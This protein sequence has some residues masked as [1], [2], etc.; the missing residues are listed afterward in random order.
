[1]F[2]LFSQVSLPAILAV[3]L[4]AMSYHPP[5]SA[6][7]PLVPP[8][9]SASFGEEVLELESV[10]IVADEELEPRERA[11]A[12]DVLTRA[13]IPEAADGVPL[14]L[15]IA[16]VPIREGTYPYFEDIRRQ[17]YRLTAGPDGI[18]IEGNSP[19]AVFHG[20]QTLDQLLKEQAIRH[21]EVHDWPDLAV[22]MIMVDP[23]RQNEN[24]DYYRRVIDFASR[25]KINA[26]LCHLTDDQTS[27]LHHED[28]PE[29]LHHEAWTPEQVE[30]LVAYAADRHIELIPEIESLGHSRMFER[31]PDFE[32]YLHQ[33]EDD[34]PDESWYGTD[35]PGYT[36]VLC[37]AS[38]KAVRYLDEMYGLAAETFGHDW[39]HVGFDEVDLTN[40]ARCREVFG[41]QTHDEWMIAALEQ[42]DRLVRQNAGR[43]GLWGDM[44]LAHPG[45]ADEFAGSDMLIFDWYY[46]AD[47][48]DESVRFFLDRDYEIIASPALACAPHMVIPD[49]NN[50]QN[51]ARFTAIA[52]E[53]SLLGVN[54]T[55]WVPVRYMSDVMWTGIGYAAAHAWGGSRFD[56]EDFFA[57]FTHHYFGSPEGEAYRQ[58]WSRL[59]DVEW[60]RPDIYTA[61]WVS[62][63]TLENARA[64]AERREDEVRRKIAEVEQVRAELAQIRP[65]ITQNEIEWRTIEHSAE[66]LQYTMEHLLAALEIDLD[67]P[68]P[69]LIEEL[70]AKC[71]ELIDVIEADWDRNRFE[72]DPGKEGR[73]LDNQHLLFRFKQMHE[74][75]TELLETWSD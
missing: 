16:A 46:R 66:I 68:S 35:I 61:A 27:V 26:I 67:D 21:G 28:Y 58:A 37:P 14:R 43:T 1:M 59:A 69:D 53:H 23:A 52:R 24:M 51:I 3:C 54:T 34:D 33:T 56:E 25:Y 18:A 10:R 31:L 41:E 12:A 39:I 17:A 45:V 44:L 60:H 30:G 11:A 8:P 70:D 65:T 48:T 32:D 57:G 71:R 2:R 63:G 4:S 22:R 62:E 64:A 47:V 29:L 7:P 72:D 42:A 49:R 36:N 19:A 5:A 9:K 15:S 20:L 50:Y 40:C 6:A 75:H 55:I 74:F 73:F 13:G 38:E